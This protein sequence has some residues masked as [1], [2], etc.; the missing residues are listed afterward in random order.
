MAYRNKN[1]VIHSV[2]W[3]GVERFSAQSIYFVF[4]FIIARRLAPSDFGLVAMLSIFMA[5]AQ[6]FIDSGFSTALIQKQ[7]R[8]KLDF[9]TVFYFNIVVAVLIYFLLIASSQLIADFYNQPQLKEIIAW[10]SLNFVISSFGTVQRAILTINLDFRRQAWISIVSVLISGSI[11]VYMAYCGY[12]VWTLVWQTLLNNLINILLLWIS[13]DWIPMFAFSV[14]SFKKLFGFSSRILVGGFIA[15][16]YNNMYTLV[17]G[18]FFPPFDLGI[19]NRA[20]TISK[21]P[22]YN[23]TGIIVRVVYPVECELQNNDEALQDKFYSFIRMTAFVVFPVMTCICVLAE[24]IVRVTL[25]DK[26]IASVPLIQIMCIAYMWDPIMRMTVDLL[27]VKH[28]SDLTLKAEIIK[29]IIAFIILFVSLYLGL[30]AICW[31][32]VLYSIVDLIIITRYT[33][34]LL[35]RVSFL[36]EI[37]NLLPILIKTAITSLVV[38]LLKWIITNDWLLLICGGV[39]GIFLYLV[40]SCLTRAPEL[41]KFKE[42]IRRHN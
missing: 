39:L 24:P 12:G 27:N 14:Q 38:Y 29:K 2:V 21:F 15:N 22:A 5:L 23:F 37:K 40:L 16:I 31:G 28:R 13:S 19:Y 35:P 18:K 8:S 34:I 7:D 4:T 36:R 33:K 11:A 41:L 6:T 1:K 25:T 9:S 3:S 30:I 10:I 20:E 26:W 32:L 42:I 17:I